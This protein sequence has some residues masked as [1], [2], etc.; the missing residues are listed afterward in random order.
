MCL[1]S[2]PSSDGQTPK[3]NLLKNHIKI[4][5]YVR[6]CRA[7]K[8]SCHNQD[9]TQVSE[10]KLCLH[11]NKS[12]S[13]SFTKKYT[14]I[15]KFVTYNNHVPK[16][17]CNVIIWAQRS[18]YVSAITLN[19]TKANFIKLHR[20]IRHHKRECHAEDIGSHTQ[21]QGHSQRSKVKSFLLKC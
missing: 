17:K 9:H 20:K 15:K 6:L 16:P 13:S 14:T 2:C 18:K 3:A 10:V 5:H 11:E 8:L 21:G 4:K 7:Q 19:S 12:F 1:K